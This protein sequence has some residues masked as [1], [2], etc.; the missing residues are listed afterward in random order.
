MPVPVAARSRSM[1]R[2]LA[3]WDCGLETHWDMDVYRECYVLS[4]RSLCCELI[5]HPEESYRLWC[6]VY[7]WSRNLVN[8]DALAQWLLLS[9][10]KDRKCMYGWM[11]VRSHLYWKV[12]DQRDVHKLFVYHTLLLSLLNICKM[13]VFLKYLIQ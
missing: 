3:C 12:V 7:V 5:I 8:E 1:P 4:G 11:D 2:P 6:V 13:C 9:Q 10:I